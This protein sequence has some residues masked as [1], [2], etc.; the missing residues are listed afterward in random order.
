[1]ARVSCAPGIGTRWASSS[2]TPT[3]R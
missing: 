1:M 3:E 2:M